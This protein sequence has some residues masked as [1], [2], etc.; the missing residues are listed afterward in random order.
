MLTCFR[1]LTVRWRILMFS[2]SFYIF[3]SFHSQCVQLDMRKWPNRS[4]IWFDLMHTLI[5]QIKN[6]SLS[7]R[8]SY[9]TTDSQLASLSWSQASIWDLRPNFLLLSLIIFRQ[10]QI[11][12]CGVPSLKRSW[13]S[14]VQPFSGLSPT[15]L[16]S[17]F[18]C[19]YFLDFPNLEGR[20]SVFI[21]PRNIDCRLGYRLKL[22]VVNIV[23]WHLNGG[24][25]EP[26]KSV[27]AR[28]RRGKYVS[29]VTNTHA[30]M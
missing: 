12:W 3:N 8:Q 21:S 29:K 6:Q 23:T 14:P 20:V 19:L 10:L 16:M 2:V 5:L 7:L 24:I 22:I 11:C 25:V 18:Y 13:A 15:G 26:E 30:T 28:Q 9:I 17:I 1:F 27:I 4:R